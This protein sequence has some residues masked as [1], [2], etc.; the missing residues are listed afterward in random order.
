MKNG[1]LVGLPNINKIKDPILG[2][3]GS[4]RNNKRLKGS[5]QMLNNTVSSAAVHGFN[6]T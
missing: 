4:I 3:E 6:S 2:Q 5:Q 1:K